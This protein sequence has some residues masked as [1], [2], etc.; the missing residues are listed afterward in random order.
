MADLM[1]PSQ[2]YL[3]EDEKARPRFFRAGT[4]RLPSTDPEVRRN[5]QFWEL[6]DSPRTSERTRERPQI[7]QRRRGVRGELFEPV[8]TTNVESP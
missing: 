5:P 4:T 3:V 2:S 8:S 7:R 1:T 6:A